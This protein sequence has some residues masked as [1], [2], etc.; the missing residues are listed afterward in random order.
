VSSLL[1]MG[2]VLVHGLRK[3]EEKRLRSGKKRTREGK[4][5][6]AGVALTGRQAKKGYILVVSE[7]PKRKE[8]KGGTQ[9]A[10]VLHGV[11]QKKRK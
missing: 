6:D 1:H 3:R 8:E 11:R 9:S 2:S 4:G 10:G 7:D 5:N